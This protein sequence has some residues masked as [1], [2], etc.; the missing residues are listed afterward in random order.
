MCR[1]GSARVTRLTGSLYAIYQH[2]GA[3]DRRHELPRAFTT[4][5]HQSGTGQV[6]RCKL[7]PSNNTHRPV[8]QNLDKYLNVISI[9]ATLHLHVDQTLADQY[10]S[11][12]E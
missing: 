12:N 5:V 10:S 4:R 3:F 1:R 7:N 2:R 6:P 9:L 8:N 11:T